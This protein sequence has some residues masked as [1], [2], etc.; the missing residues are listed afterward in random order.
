M[1]DDGSELVTLGCYGHVELR[2]SGGNS[3]YIKFYDGSNASSAVISLATA[4][5]LAE[6]IYRAIKEIQE[7]D[8]AEA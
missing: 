5:R 2:G 6:A 3:I 8:D 1:V 4:E 7:A